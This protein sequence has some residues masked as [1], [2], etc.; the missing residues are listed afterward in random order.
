VGEAAEVLRPQQV[1]LEV[2]QPQPKRS[3]QKR[4]RRKRSQMRIWAS[5]SLTKCSILWLLPERYEVDYEHG[6]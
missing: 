6:N 3:R 1:E 4:K 2:L 5:V